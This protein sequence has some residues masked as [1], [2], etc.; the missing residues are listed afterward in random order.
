MRLT[1]L[2]IKNF[3]A[4]TDLILDELD[5]AVVLAGPNG[6]GKSCVLDGIRLLKSAYGSYEQDEWQTWF[7]EFQIDLNRE[8][9][10]LLTLL[11]DRSTEL[12]IR[13]TFVLSPEEQT[14]ISAR[15]QSLLEEKAWRDLYPQLGGRIRALALAAEQRAN[16]GKVDN[17][18]RDT[19][20]LLEQSLS[21]L[22]HEAVLTIQPFG[23]PQVTPNPLLE[24][25][26]STYEP[27]SLGIVDYHGPNRNYNRERL[28][29]INLTI[30]ASEQ[31]L[32]QHALYNYSNKYANLKTEMGSAYVRH[33]LARQADSSIALDDSLTATLK[34]LFATFFPGKEFLGPQPRS[35]GSLLFQVRLSNGAEHDIDDLSS[36]EKEVL[37]GYL[38][39]HNAAPKHSVLLIDEPEL[40]LNPRLISGLA[41]FYYH[42]LGAQLNN[43]L[44]LVT[45]SDTLIREAVNHPRFAVFHIHPAGTKT[46]NQATPVRA[47]AELD[48]V[49]LE[50]VGDLAAYR[51]NAKVVVFESSED[52]AFDMRMTCTL[53]PEF[54]EKVNTVSAG[55]KS[56]V[57][58]L[59]E[60]LETVRSAGHIT[61]RFYAITDS[62]DDIQQSPGKRFQWDVYHIENYLLEPNYILSAL[63]AVGVEPEIIADELQVLNELKECAERTMNT[64]ITHRLRGYVNKV[65]VNSINL[66]SAP[67]PPDAAMALFE[68]LGRSRQRIEHVCNS[69]FSSEMLSKLQQQFAREYQVALEDGSW[70]RKFRGRDVLSQ[71][72]GRFVRGMSYEYFRDLIITRMS[73]SHYQPAGMTQIISSILLD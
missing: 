39:L 30:E 42:H 16:R 10:E 66:G 5:D 71:F 56:R 68:A 28:G 35:D 18:V 8:P 12:T 65:V 63:R 9:E 22:T 25:L 60:L 55:N 3:R 32:K 38:R 1:K 6:C 61:Q 37:Y 17:Y 43:Q 23:N 48:R 11:Q 27:Q 67:S 31:R 41:T 34:E 73:E 24:L 36:G 44:W 64:L 20:P 26:F 4:I 59:Y 70:I 50:L 7:G 14:F 57:I 52:A 45:H 54:E 13:G 21:S 29:N 33:L 19:L 69:Q 62:D 51:P 49:V 40:H 58:D 15:A 72:A 53:F 2:H 47:E 46:D